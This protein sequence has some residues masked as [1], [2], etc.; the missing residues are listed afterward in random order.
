M[1]PKCYHKCSFKREAEGSCI[2]IE[3]EPKSQE[4][5]GSWPQYR[6]ADKLEEAKYPFFP[7]ASGGGVASL[8]P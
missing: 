5:G 6:N 1:G 2:H 7:Q 3:E 8:T 4:M